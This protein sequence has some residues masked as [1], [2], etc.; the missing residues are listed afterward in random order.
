M[1]T[2]K[3]KPFDLEAAKRGEL[4]VARE[5][6]SARF[7]AHVTDCAEGFRVVVLIEGCDGCTSH[8][9][10]GRMHLHSECRR[11][12]FMAPRKVTRWV[13]LHLANRLNRTGRAFYYG[14]E[15]DARRSAGETAIAIA[16]PVEIEE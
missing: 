5:G 15:E 11:D 8:Y 14:T 9:E 12:L 13:N 1:D 4:I 3:L 6:Q 7:V 10:N 2:K 16:V